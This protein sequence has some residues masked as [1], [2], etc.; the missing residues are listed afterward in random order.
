MIKICSECGIEQELNNENFEPRKN[1]KDGFRNQCRDCRNKSRRKRYV[2]SANNRKWTEQEKEILIKQYPLI[3]AKE[4]ESKFLPDRTAEQI[5]DYATKKLKLKKDVSFKKSWNPD[6]ISYLKENYRNPNILVKEIA[7]KINKSVSTVTAM[8]NSLG[9]HRESIWNEEEKSLL[10]LYYPTMETSVLQDEILKDKTVSQITK[11]ANDNGILKN[12][13]V[14]YQIRKNTAINNLKNI[15]NTKE[16]T[17]PEIVIID[18]LDKLD[19]N[20]LFQEHKKY[21]W[22]DFYIPEKNLV[23]EVQGDYFHCNPLLDLKYNVLDKKGI[24]SKDK[25]KNSYFK[26]KDINILYLWESDIKNSIEKCEVLIKKYLDNNGHLDNY[27]S[28]NYSLI[29]KELI[30]NNDSVSIGY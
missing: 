7:E 20:Y 22:V 13:N 2:P 11:F 19:V 23:I 27:H 25:R 1:T 29:N 26:N 10:K 16:P 4:I 30:K 14:A 28:F 21:Y 24:I 18:I 12:Q 5:M 8:A 6:Q 15:N 17:K 3:G 9:L